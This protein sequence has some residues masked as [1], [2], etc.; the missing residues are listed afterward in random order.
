MGNGGITSGNIKWATGIW[1]LAWATGEKKKARKNHDKD[2]A[3]KPE[4]A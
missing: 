1:G 4:F 3:V 2:K